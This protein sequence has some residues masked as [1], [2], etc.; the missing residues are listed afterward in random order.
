M[1][2]KLGKKE[3]VKPVGKKMK[4]R[5][6]EVTVRTEQ[7]KIYNKMQALKRLVNCK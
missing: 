6:R 3:I 1:D 4:G 5:M 7:A 2:I